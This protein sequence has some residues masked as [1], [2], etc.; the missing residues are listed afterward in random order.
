[1]FCFTLCSKSKMVLVSFTGEVA[2]SKSSFAGEVEMSFGD[3][4]S[5]DGEEGFE[6]FG[7]DLVSWVGLWMI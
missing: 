1:M 6:C 5:L 7:G 3:F 4:D 2:E